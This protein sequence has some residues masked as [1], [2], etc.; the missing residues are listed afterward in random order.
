[1]ESLTPRVEALA[2]SLRAPVSEGDAQ[3]EVRRN[4]LA[5]YYVAFQGREPNLMHENF[6]E[7]G[8]RPPGSGLQPKNTFHN[9]LTT[10]RMHRRSMVWWK[11]FVMP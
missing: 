6:Q 3:E 1:L 11:I 8:S 7:T 9:S 10:L 2:E 4:E 5:R